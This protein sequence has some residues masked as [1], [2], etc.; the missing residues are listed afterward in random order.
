MISVCTAQ[1]V[2]TGKVINKSNEPVS[3]A[4]VMLMTT[5]DSTV[6]AFNFSNDNGDYTLRTDR[7]DAEF[8]IMAHG[9]NIKRNIK[10]TPNKSQTVNIV[11][12][13][14]ALSL[15]EVSVKSGKIWGIRDT[16]N[17]VVDAFRDST[18]VVI[19]DVLKKMP[20]IEVEESGEIK[21]R[22]K[23]ISKFYIEN[24]DMLQGRYGVATNNITASD[25]A[26]VQVFE[27]HQPIKALGDIKFTD[28]EL[29][30]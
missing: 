28:D 8:L 6:I 4:S 24:V 13:E 2:I 25:I 29:Q 10:K 20:G 27:N 9:F 30:I 17:Y 16:V 3:N 23:Q 18:D 14:E 26:T 15:K 1:T 21:Y 12:S 22:G 19:G 5:S 7:K 11:V